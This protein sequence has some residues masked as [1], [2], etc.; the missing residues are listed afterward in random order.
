VPGG[1]VGGGS[2][3]EQHALST[4]IVR[5]HLPSGGVSPTASPNCSSSGL[6]TTIAPGTETI[7]GGIIFE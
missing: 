2:D 3:S 5:T 6:I 4:E 1:G 7:H